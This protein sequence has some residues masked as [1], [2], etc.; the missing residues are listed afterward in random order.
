MAYNKDKKR[1]QFALL[2]LLFF[3]KRNG[4]GDKMG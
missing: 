3:D 1:C 2:D 4:L